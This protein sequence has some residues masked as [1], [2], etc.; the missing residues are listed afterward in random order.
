MFAQCVELVEYMK[1]GKQI[2]HAHVMPGQVPY[3]PAAA[4]VCERIHGPYIGMRN[5]AVNY[6][7]EYAMRQWRLTQSGLGEVGCE[8]TQDPRKGVR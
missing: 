8:A 6:Q 3:T 7:D 5:S 4:I 1:A 2:W